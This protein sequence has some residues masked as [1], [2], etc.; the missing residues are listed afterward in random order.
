M[1]SAIEIGSSAE[2]YFEKSVRMWENL[3]KY[4]QHEIEIEIP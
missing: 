4:F 3:R 2:I 1:T